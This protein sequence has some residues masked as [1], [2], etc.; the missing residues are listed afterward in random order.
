MYHI[1]RLFSSNH[2][3][4]NNINNFEELQVWI[5]NEE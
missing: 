2:N 3:T 5:G 4:N 1:G